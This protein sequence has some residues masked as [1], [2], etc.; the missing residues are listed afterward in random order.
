MRLIR[1][2]DLATRARRLAAIALVAVALA[3]LAIAPAGRAATPNYPLGTGVEMITFHV[4]GQYTATTA[5]VAKWL[6][7]F[8]AKLIGF[9]ASARASGGTSPTLTVDLKQGGTTMLSAPVSL[10]AG[11]PAEGTLA[12]STIAD[13]ATMTVDFTIGGT[14]PTWNDITIIVTVARL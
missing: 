9:S 11:T 4:S 2:L 10:T 14:S 1:L 13:E 3:L 8:K 5:G 12:S 6:Q 7:P